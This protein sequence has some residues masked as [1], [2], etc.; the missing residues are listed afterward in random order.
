[1]KSGSHEPLPGC[2]IACM[3][4]PLEVFSLVEPVGVFT[5]SPATSL[6]PGL[7]GASAYNVYRPI[8]DIS[9]R[10]ST[11]F[12]LMSMSMPIALLLLMSMSFMR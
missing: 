7:T 4:E 3:R 11:V 10:P 2:I 5:P 8:M 12:M 1:M 9:P 6:W